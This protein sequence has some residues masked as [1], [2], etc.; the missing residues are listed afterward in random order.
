MTQND[1]PPIGVIKTYFKE[2]FG[3]PRQ[4]GM[5]PEARA[6][7]KL[8][9][10]PDY[11]RALKHLDEFSHLWVL[12]VF[13]KHIDLKWKP[14]IHPPR[15]GAPRDIGVFA[16]RSPHRPNPIGMSAVKLDSIDWDARGGIE[17]HVSNVDFLDETPILDI[18]PYLPYTDRI[19][20]AH[21]GWAE[22]KIPEYVVSFSN[23]SEITIQEISL[24]R[25]PGL[26]QLL[27]EMLRWDP[28]PTSQKSA[29]PIED[30]KNQEMHFG[31]RCLDFDVQWK[32]KDFGIY[33][34]A[35]VKI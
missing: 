23:E 28:R 14:T 35:L 4:S 12:F 24:S 13:H 5:V 16:S 26:R 6:V 7:L 21:G 11:K 32:I 25:H 2:K 27:F 22:G 19:L 31:F 30:S 8:F 1:Y 17:I 34:L 3:V 18:K 15:I 10:V 9:D 20:E 29:F 33:V